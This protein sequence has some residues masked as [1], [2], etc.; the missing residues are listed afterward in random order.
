VHSS[1]VLSLSGERCASA[2][3]SPMNGA[4]E[5]SCNAEE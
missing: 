4:L 2:I 1:V 3:T 5:G